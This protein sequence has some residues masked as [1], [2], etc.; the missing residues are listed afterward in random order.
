MAQYVIHKIGFFYTDEAFEAVEDARGSIVGVFKTLEEAN[1]A[2]KAEEIKSMQ[3]IAGE[4]LSHFFFYNAN[5]DQIVEKTVQYFY[6]ELGVVIEDTNFIILP[7][8]ITELQAK[9]LLEITEISFHSIIEYDEK[10]VLD[11]ED[12]D[13]VEQDLDEF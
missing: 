4:N 5:Y 11:V 10:V 13:L 8:S 6:T 12:Y 3:N 1:L 9:T 7:K 2:K